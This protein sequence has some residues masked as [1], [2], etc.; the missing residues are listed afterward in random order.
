MSAFT[1]KKINLVSFFVNFL[2]QSDSRGSFF[3]TTVFYQNNK[4]YDFLI[5]SNIERLGRLKI[6]YKGY[7]PTFFSSES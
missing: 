7:Q 1:W 2:A 6:E 3:G 4:F 5:F